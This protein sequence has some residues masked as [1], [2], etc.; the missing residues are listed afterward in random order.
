MNQTQVP[1]QFSHK[2]TYKFSD[3]IGSAE[4]VRSLINYQNLPPF[5]YLWGPRFA[6]KTFLTL[7][8]LEHLKSDG[9]GVVVVDALKI[10]DQELVEHL[11]DTVDFLLVED[12]CQLNANMTNETALFNL[13]NA[14]TAR[15]KKLLVTA[16]L[17]QRSDDWQL[18]DLKSRL[19]SGLILSLDVLKG[20][21]AVECIRKQ[22]A[23]HG[24]PMD[25]AVINYLKTTQN[26][27]LANLYPL[28]E[29]L[30]L[31]SLKLK[32]KVTI[33]MIKDV[34]ADIQQSEQ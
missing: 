33:P 30:S 11:L 12:V 24:M 18:P 22:F 29:R 27:S 7:A 3:F 14:C 9:Y 20:D 31:N 17:P 28:F 1:L 8:L 23:T 16:T 34:I 19:N 26:T 13:Y 2:D 25:E 21:D 10:L 4:V 5:T 32:R 15:Q 6:G